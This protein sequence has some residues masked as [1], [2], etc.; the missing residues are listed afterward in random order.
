MQMRALLRATRTAWAI[1]DDALQ[2]IIDISM[3]VN[4]SPELVA[5]ELGR[6]LDNTYDVSVRDGVAILPIRGPLIKYGSFFTRIS[7]ATSYELLARDFN[8]A[9]KNPDVKSILLDIDSPGGEAN[10]V[11]ELADMIYAARGQK[12]ITAY[13]S[14]LG[15]SGAY[16]L[17][18]SADEIVINDIGLAGSIGAILGFRDTTEKDIKNGVK[19]VRIVSSQS[20]HKAPDPKTKEG[21]ELIQTTLDDIAGVFIEKVATYRGVDTE[22]VLAEF[23][24]G[25]VL[26][27]KK[28]VKA[29]LADRVG[30]FED[31]LLNLSSNSQ[32][33]FSGYSTTT[34]KEG[35]MAQETVETKEKSTKKTAPT[36]TAAYVQEN[37]ADVAL[38]LGSIGA[39][40]ERKRINAILSCDEANGRNDLA[41][42]IATETDLTVEAAVTLL[43]KSPVETKTGGNAFSTA[44]NELENPDVGADGHQSEAQASAGWGSAFQKVGK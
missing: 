27:G 34:T 16:W 24:Q 41:V 29:G 9:L 2:S 33:A 10:G 36:V 3:R 21:K 39:A 6:D 32:A 18:A 38:E 43:G 5:K 26:M 19:E 8:T 1:T 15:A 40:S 7:G 22:T 25:N 28:A 13:V 31:V 37:H 17:A 14:G 11:S 12:P 42:S 4:D 44:M 30:S 23:G 20:P 35:V